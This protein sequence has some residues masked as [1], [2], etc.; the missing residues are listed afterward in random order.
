MLA[1]NPL[2]ERSAASPPFRAAAIRTLAQ[3]RLALELV[4]VDP[5]ARDL[6]STTSNHPDPDAPLGQWLYGTWWSGH[7]LRPAAPD[8]SASALGAAALESARRGVARRRLDWLVLAATADLLVAAQLRG[9]ERVHTR[10]DAVVGSSRPGMAPRP[11]DLV[12][13]VAGSSGLDPAR[14]WWW[15][16]TDDTDPT[17]V[18]LDRWYVHAAGLD[19]AVA[20]VPV[21]L[22]ALE[23]AGC[24]A[25]L[26]CPPT[27]A[28]FGRR[29][30]L[31]VY[32]P[33]AGA[34]SAEAALVGSADLLAP[35]VRGEIPPFTR[36]LLP[37][38]STAQDPGSWRG[39]ELEPEA[40]RRCRGGARVG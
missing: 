2:A 33:R 31:V 15:A 39:P 25:S 4:W 40:R 22:G 34:A 20:L 9:G 3:A 10:V 5:V 36:Q 26:K 24:S 23:S 19:S 11:G 29:D 17:G 28:L 6:R 16:T 13:L 18:P 30:A 7:T 38:V 8:D 12:D 32:L 14:C 27:E 37:G 21:L 1:L 35:H